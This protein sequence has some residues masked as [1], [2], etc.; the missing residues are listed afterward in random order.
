MQSKNVDRIIKKHNA[1]YSKA[2]TNNVC[3]KKQG[4]VSID[5][6]CKQ[7]EK[8]SSV[9]DVKISE[10][11]NKLV[12][13]SIFEHNGKNYPLDLKIL[14]GLLRPLTKLR[15]LIGLTKVK[16]AIVDMVLYYLQN[17]EKGNSHMLHTVIEG[18]P[19]VGKQNWV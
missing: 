16:E 15:S 17:F 9:N 5:D 18:P 11:K 4:Y 8:D 6:V 19:G 7:K 13:R 2:S 1:K 3:N 12:K 10:D 14:H